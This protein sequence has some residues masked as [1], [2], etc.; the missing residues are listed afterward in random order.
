M[1]KEQ[2]ARLVSRFHEVR[3]RVSDPK[4]MKGAILAE[5]LARKWTEDMV[6]ETSGEVITIERNELICSPNRIISDDDVQKI[7]FH[8]QAGDIKDVLITNQLRTGRSWFGNYQHNFIV[9]I[10]SNDDD[11]KA[12]KKNYLVRALNPAMAIQIAEDVAEQLFDN[13]FRIDQV[14]LEKN[15]IYSSSDEDDSFYIVKLSLCNKGT[16]NLEE[17]EFSKR[18]MVVSAKDSDIANAMAIGI[19][20]S[21]LQDEDKDK[22]DIIPIESKPYSLNEIIP[23]DFCKEYMENKVT[24]EWLMDGQRISTKSV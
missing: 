4:D 17:D 18:T 7:M 8:Q 13:I 5:R 21:G 23:Y 9:S 2:A 1:K 11:G 3:L 15:V 6:D 10:V 16:G 14:K 22:Y 24:E 20:K 19:I 12:V